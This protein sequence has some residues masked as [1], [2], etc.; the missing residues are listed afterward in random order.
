VK[1]VPILS[2]PTFDRFAIVFPRRACP[3]FILA[4][5]LGKKRGHAT[6]LIAWSAHVAN[7]FVVNL[8]D[9]NEARIVAD[10]SK[11]K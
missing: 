8:Q 1:N 4:T 9:G 6:F 11:V 10:F 5:L 2:R 3:G 7:A